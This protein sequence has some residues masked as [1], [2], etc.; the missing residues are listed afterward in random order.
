[1]NFLKK[2]LIY[3]K[4]YY[5]KFKNYECCIFIDNQVKNN[6]T[7]TPIN[8]NYI[9]REIKNTNTNTNTKPIKINCEDK[10]PKYIY[11]KLKLLSEIKM[12]NTTNEK[13]NFVKKSNYI[14]L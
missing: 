5:I 14:I 10:F 4:K 13:E 2:T 1:M 3:I 11:N 8:I 9:N 6:K 7:P 12:I